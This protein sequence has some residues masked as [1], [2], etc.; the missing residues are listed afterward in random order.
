MGDSTRNSKL[1]LPEIYWQLPESEAKRQQLVQN[2]KTLNPT[3]G[4]LSLKGK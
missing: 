4:D 3:T 1:H 2:A